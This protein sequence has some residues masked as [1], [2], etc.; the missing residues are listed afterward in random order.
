[1]QIYV[2][3]FEREYYGLDGTDKYMF[4]LFIF[5]GVIICNDIRPH[6]LLLLVNSSKIKN[7]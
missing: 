1:M 2:R 5:V 3:T 6:H 4:S 7:I